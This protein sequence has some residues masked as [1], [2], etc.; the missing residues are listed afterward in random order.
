MATIN[1]TSGSDN[2][3]GT[4]GADQV[5]GLGGTDNLVG[6]NG[7]DVLEGGAG[8][9]EVFGS[10][11]FDLASYKSSNQGVAI[12]LGG[13]FAKGG[14][15]AGDHLYSIEGVIGSA[16]RDVLDGSD[17]RN[18]LRGEGGDD[19]L[20]GYGGDDLLEGGAGNDELDGGIAADE[21]RGGTGRD[22]AYY[23]LS[24]AAVRIDLTT[25]LGSGGYADGD[26]L[27]DIEDVFGSAR[28]DT[29]LGNAAANRLY[30][31]DGSD[32]IS[33]GAG[34]DVIA[35][36]EGSDQ[37]D[38]GAGIDTLDYSQAVAAV[39]VELAAGRG[40]AGAD[41]DII[42][43]FERVI[44]SAFA[45]RLLG[46]GGANALSG[47]AGDDFLLGGLGRDEFTGGTGADRFRF[48]FT[49]ESGKTAT[50]RDIVR[51]FHHGE[52]HLDLSQLDAAAGRAGDQ[53]P[54]FIGQK[55]FTAEGQVRFFYEGNNTVVEVN[56]AGSSGADMQ[57]QLDGRVQLAASDFFFID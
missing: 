15:A 34:D 30:G 48:S 9:D 6:Y 40:E 33:G 32:V 42:A 47:G 17:Q 49:S 29:L 3:K 22:L 55:A 28:G 53:D 23:G 38:G 12:D 7:D 13:F 25:G 37:L 44:G 18:V 20:L 50:T 46:D 14:H 36:G 26:R 31:Y 21:L 45:D 57:I 54:T 11:G 35:G 1:G 2:L 10:D 41:R 5:F 43:G 16:Y 39:G 51:D 24:D 52:D 8:A 4:A 27:F 56:T 19:L